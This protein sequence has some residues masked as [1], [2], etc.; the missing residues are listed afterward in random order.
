MGSIGEPVQL[1]R[2]ALRQRRKLE[3][4]NDEGVRMTVQE[5]L[6]L[7][8]EAVKSNEKDNDNSL[9]NDNLAHSKLLGLKSLI[10][11]NKRIIL[12]YHSTRLDCISSIVASVQSV[13]SKFKDCMTANELQ[14]ASEY[15]N[16]LHEFNEFYNNL[17]IFTNPT[18]PREL[19]IQIRVNRDCGLIQTEYGQ[20]YLSPN[21]LHYVRRADIQA[22]I[23]QGMVS[24]VR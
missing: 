23:D 13:P 10:E 6:R 7:Y 18:P 16:M 11:R 22:L 5:I 15:S 19:Y 2:E 8:E 1:V 20:L 14:F 4:Y 24:H 9:F 21:S 3:P 17:D 12:A